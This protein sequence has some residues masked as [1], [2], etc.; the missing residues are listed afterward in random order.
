MRE[1][2][3]LGARWSRGRLKHL[4]RDHIEIDEPGQDAMP[5]VLKFT[6]QHMSWLHRQ[7][8]MLALSGLHPSQLIQTDGAFTLPGSLWGL[9]YTSHPSTIFSSRRSSGTA[10]NQNRNRCAWRPLFS[11]VVQH[12]V[13]K[14]ARRCLAP[15]SHQ[16]SRAR[17][18]THRSSRFGRSF[19]GQ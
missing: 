7:V 4:P 1:G 19:T 9:A 15:S 2:I 11:A 10:V 17:P 6:P 8:G 16:Q 5:D 14:S 12:A 3:L 13:A 18:L